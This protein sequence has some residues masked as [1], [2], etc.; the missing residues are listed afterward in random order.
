M[1]HETGQICTPS[2]GIP[3]NNDC[4]C[5]IIDK[6]ALNEVGSP[7]PSSIDVEEI[8]QV[9]GRDILKSSLL[10]DIELYLECEE[11]NSYD[12][13]CKKSDNG[14][15]FVLPQLPPGSNFRFKV[16]FPNLPTVN[17]ETRYPC[18]LCD[19]SFTRESLLKDHYFR[20]H[21]EKDLFPCILCRYKGSLHRH[22]QKHM[23]RKHSDLCAKSQPCQE[24]AN[25]TAT[26]NDNVITLE[27]DSST[28][29]AQ[30]FTH[31]LRTFP[32]VGASQ[33]RLRASII[34]DTPNDSTKPTSTKE[35]ECHIEILNI[36]VWT[37]SISEN[38]AAEIGSF[39]CHKCKKF[40]KTTSALNEHTETVHDEKIHTCSNRG[41]TKKYAFE[42]DLKAHMVGHTGK[43]TCSW[44]ACQRKFRDSF[45]LKVHTKSH[46]KLKQGK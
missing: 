25:H 20:Q 22:L 8:Y 31:S 13:P 5:M 34:E 2:T 9:L 24:V 18:E 16:T 43:F 39:T 4:L 15:R 7:H 26:L 21:G 10:D 45:N 44:P 28:N 19:K 40:L 38:R 32:V 41:C 46:S 27:H 23:K 37:K 29:S 6:D 30:S 1:A 3:C 42:R 33:S 14:C 35:S 12:V 11:D 17:E 36:P